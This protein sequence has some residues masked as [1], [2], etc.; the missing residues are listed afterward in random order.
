MI[1]LGLNAYHGD[2]SA[3]LLV[4]GEL[5]AAAEEERFNR[6]KH[7]AGFPRLAVEYCLASAGAR[8]DDV[9]HIAIG[10][11][12]R[13]H[14]P[15]KLSFAV[16][17]PPSFQMIADRFRN[18][19]KARS[20]KSGLAQ[21]LGVD[22]ERI[23]A[24]THAVEHHRAH[25][26]SAFFASG[27]DDAGVTSVDGFGDFVSTM[28]GRGTGTTLKVSRRVS[29][30]HSL[31]IFYSAM[32]QYLGFPKYGDEYKVMGLAAY[33]TPDLKQ[34][35]RNVL[36][37]GEGAFKLDLEFFQHHSKGV[38]MTWEGE[39][40]YD[41]IYTDK[42][43]ELLGP[44][45]APGA[46]MLDRFKAVAASTQSLFEDALF[47]ILR[48]QWSL[49]QTPRLCLAGGCAHNSLAAGK[50]SQL[51]PFKDV[52]IQPAA[53]DAGTAL[54]AALFVQHEKLGQPR[55]FVQ[56]A[57]SYG[58]QFDQQEVEALLRKEGVVFHSLPDTELIARVARDIDG[59]AVVGWF[60]GRME[61]GPRALGNRS[62]L[63]DPRRADM[64]QI[65]NERIKRRESFRPFAP[66]LPLERVGDYFEQTA[67]D[68]FMTKVYRIKED[69]RAQLPAITHVDGT[70]RLQ[71]VTRK[72]NPRYYDLLVEFGRLTGVPI[73]LNTSFNENEPIVCTPK[74]A[75]DCYL[76]TKMDVLVLENAY[77]SRRNAA[78]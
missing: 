23:R 74:Q 18:L 75:L 3:A 64:Q 22:G 62:M 16:T 42:L 7:C 25:M 46:P 41:R 27:F 47:E 15:D 28:W 51:T 69:K 40:S 60:Q 78:A 65:M 35:L 57:S 17:N 20:P 21:S 52:F 58:P 48:T 5:V 2:A 33:G 73:L 9:D 14:L 19:L 45:R 24:V 29:F 55:R 50:I 44:P 68:P 10:R 4:D 59:G 11:N 72:E 34:A 53:G 63:A 30:P 76:R 39:P 31:G 61:W 49:T 54:G 13:A 26:A 43:I 66:A 1:V 12:P 32:T 67:P 70:G 37:V 71:T 38:A 8:I 77:L 6:V 56:T 36:R